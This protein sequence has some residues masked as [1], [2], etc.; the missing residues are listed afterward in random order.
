MLGH[1]SASYFRPSPFVVRKRRLGVG[2]D[3]SADQHSSTNRQPVGH[4]SSEPTNNKL[5]FSLPNQSRL[6]ISDFLP[7]KIGIGSR[8]FD[9]LVELVTKKRGIRVQFQY[10][11]A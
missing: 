7:V 1:S 11:L 5:S 10:H 3:Q 4:S 9:V 8:A 2:E 6:A